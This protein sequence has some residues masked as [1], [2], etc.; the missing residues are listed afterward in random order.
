MNRDFAKRLAR[1]ERMT[2]KPMPGRIVMTHLADAEL[3]LLANLPCSDDALRSHLDA[4][5]DF[6]WQ[7]L[8]SV[9]EKA[10]RGPLEDAPSTDPAPASGGIRAFLTE[11]MELTHQGTHADV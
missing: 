8:A 2:G 9:V 1:L 5:S 4:L 6:D 7:A 10:H 3:E 11:R